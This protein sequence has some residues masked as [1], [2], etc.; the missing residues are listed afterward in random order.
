MEFTR[1][2]LMQDG[3]AVD[4]FATL[5]QAVAAAVRHAADTG[6]PAA[7]M[8]HARGGG[9][10]E[11]VFNP[12]GT[13]EKIWNID[14]GKPLT[15]AAGQVYANRGGGRYLCLSAGTVS[16]PVC[17][18]AAGCA[19]GAS[20]VFRNV[21]SGWTFTAKGIVQYADGTIEWDHGVDG[22]FEDAAP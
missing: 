18:N 5:E 15:P 13:N 19:S 1:F 7:V 12:D 10:R 16:G 3:K 21:A 6:K 4:G 14:K 9:T 11:A 20:G 8:A 22:R 17:F 2:T